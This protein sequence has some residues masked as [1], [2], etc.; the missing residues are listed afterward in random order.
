MSGIVGAA[1]AVLVA[2]MVRDIGMG[3]LLPSKLG[4]QPGI[5]SRALASRTLNFILLKAG[6]K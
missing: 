5:W 3:F 1:L 6:M 2:T 4:L